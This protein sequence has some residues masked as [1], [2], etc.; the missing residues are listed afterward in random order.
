MSADVVR[1]LPALGGPATPFWTGGAEAEL[2][3]PRCTGCKALL[4]PSVTVCPHCL[5][6]ELPG[7][8]VAGPAVVVGRTTNEKMGL[9]SMPPPYSLAVV[10][11]TAA[12]DV[13]LTTNV[14]GC[15]P[16]QVEVG[17]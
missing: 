17:M 1:P 13:R 8:A 6:S 16:H 5:G 11:L 15:D 7:K 2:R 12:P 4:H 3:L 9:P 14:V 10:S